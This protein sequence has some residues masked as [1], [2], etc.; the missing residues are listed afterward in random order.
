M[1]EPSDSS[2]PPQPP[3]AGEP[4]P[5]ARRRRLG[6]LA[7]LLVVLLAGAA[8]ASSYFFFTRGRRPLPG[9][10]VAPA[11]RKTCVAVLP[12]PA[13]PGSEEAAWMGQAAFGFLPFALEDSADLRVLTAE[14][15]HDL[16]RG[17]LPPSVAG[18]IDV[19]KR[20]G[21]DFLL[22]GQ[23]TGKAAEASLKVFWIEMPSGRELDRWSVE[24]IHPDNLGRKLDEIYTRVRSNLHLRVEEAGPTDPPLTSLVPIRETPTRSY[25]EA[26]ALFA[27]G[28]TAGC[29]K[30][31]PEALTL[32]DFHL[33]HFLQAEAAARA[34]EVGTAVAAAGRLA[35]VSRP[36]PARVVLMTPVILAIYKSGNPRTAVGPLESFLARFPDEKVPLSWLGAIEILLLN[37]PDQARE[38]LRK[39]FNLD[40]TDTDTQRLL[41]QASL[42]AGH[43][44]EAV[45]LLEG[46]LKAK[47]DDEQARLFF[48]DALRRAGR[49]EDSR[50]EAEAFLSRRPDS[51]RAVELLGSILLAQGHTKEAEELYGKLTRSGQPAVRSEGEVLLGQSSLLQGRFNDGIRHFRSAVDSAAAQKDV[52]T[53]SRYLQDLAVV[54]SSLGR[55]GEA[56]TTLAQIR[57]L[58]TRSDPDLAMINIV[59]AQ[60]QFDTARKLLD[61]QAARWQGRI[62]GAVL[63]RLRDALEGSIALEQ[64]K[65]PEAVKRLEASLP[66]ARKNPPASE[67]LGRAYLGA[68]DAAR[69]EQVFRKIIED[70]DRFEDSTRFVRSLVRLGES[71]EKLGKKEEALRRYGEAIQWWGNA[72]FSLPET[73]Q[74]REG[75]KRL[76]G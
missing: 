61:E 40:P 57:G 12:F 75:I 10:A 54:E 27:K 39:S 65:Y 51:P 60:K 52:T 19:A 31:L 29:L 4:D 76:G 22:R 45:P 55:N 8:I 36:L 67:T 30:A 14:R 6:P 41:G 64:G 33:A 70:P 58:D 73:T 53:Q 2:I 63:Q 48:I 74:A 50:R 28:D 71:C 16:S 15:L 24:G 62:S 17:D 68:G 69:A 46:F 13:D 42:A 59:V 5:R 49:P 72:D 47:P 11:A 1:N 23:V 7:P 20:G 18:Q 66:D 25:L 9:T 56:L 32:S 37:E 26:S 43:P 35:K 21:A 38:T 3:P 34:G 44:A